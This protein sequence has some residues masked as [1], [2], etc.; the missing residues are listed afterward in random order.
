MKRKFSEFS[1]SKMDVSEI[2]LYVM[3]HLISLG[4][5]RRFYDAYVAF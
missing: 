5:V 3:I 4:G 1:T 2:Q